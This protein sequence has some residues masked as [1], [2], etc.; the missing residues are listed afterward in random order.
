M[1]LDD[2]RLELRHLRYDTE[3]LRQQVAEAALSIAADRDRLTVGE[4]ALAVLEARTLKLQ[5]EQAAKYGQVLANK[6]HVAMLLRRHRAE[7]TDLTKHIGT[8]LNK[9]RHS[10]RLPSAFNGTLRWPLIGDISQEYG[11]THFALEPPKGACDHFHQGIDIV[12][13]EGAPVRAP[14]DGIVLWVGYETT[15]ARKDANYYVM[16]A[17]SDHL[18]SIYGHL[19]PRSPRTLKVGTKVIEGQVLG[20]EGNT[21]NSTGPHLHWGL[22]LDGEPTNPRFFL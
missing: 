5:A 12:A 15:V 1:L 21:G 18:V 3:S 14:G 7:Q 13:A 16:I 4:E 19:Q 10:G 9:E 22:W 17:H 6:A 20:W 11:C 8:L 2:Q